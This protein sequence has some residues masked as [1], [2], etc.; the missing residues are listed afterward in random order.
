MN[1]V[2]VVIFTAACIPHRIHSCSRGNL[3]ELDKFYLLIRLLTFFSF[4]VF[5][6][7]KNGSL[8]FSMEGSSSFSLTFSTEIRLLL[9]LFLLLIKINRRQFILLMLSDAVL[10]GD[11]PQV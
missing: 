6:Q 11:F 4:S 3:R 5:I 8:F 10:A 9:M 7:L 2:C 1:S